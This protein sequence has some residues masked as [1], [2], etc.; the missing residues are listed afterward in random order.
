MS[1]NSKANKRERI[2][3]CDYFTME[4]YTLAEAEIFENDGTS[5]ISL[6]AQ[7]SAIVVKV[8]G[9]DYSVPAGRSCLIPAGIKN[10]TVEGAEPSARILVV[11][12]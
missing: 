4:R 2:L 5:F 6:F 10:F 11:H 1:A 3:R 7:N 9:V 12:I 8:D